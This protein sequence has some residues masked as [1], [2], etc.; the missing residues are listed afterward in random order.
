MQVRS[1]IPSIT[2]YID[3]KL[4][5]SRFLYWVRYFVVRGEIV[6]FFRIL[7]EEK[8][9]SLVLSISNATASTISDIRSDVK[10]IRISSAMEPSE[11]VENIDPRRFV[12]APEHPA[13]PGLLSSSGDFVH[14]AQSIHG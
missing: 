11:N 6:E 9:S 2:N 7:N 5:K 8:K 10:M 14:S 4:G 1:I 12:Q 3:E 13:P